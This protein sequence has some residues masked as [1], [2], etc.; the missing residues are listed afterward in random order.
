[1]VNKSFTLGRVVMA[2]I[3]T[4]ALG[5]LAWAAYTEVLP[6]QLKHHVVLLILGIGGMAL[7]SMGIG[8]VG[9]GKEWLHPFSILG[10]LLGAA[11]L[12]VFI[13]GLAGWQL[14]LVQTSRQAIL[15]L[16]MLIVAKWLVSQLHHLLRSLKKTSK[17]A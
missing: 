17:T 4:A 16:G 2:T 14:P 8:A 10:Y 3:F 13:S 6:W 5:W 7:C 12:L 11:A 15:A 9:A 1:M